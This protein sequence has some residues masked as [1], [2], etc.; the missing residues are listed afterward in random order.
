MVASPNAA[1]TQQRPD[2]Y[3]IFGVLAVSLLTFVMQFAMVSVSLE[4]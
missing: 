3:L 1:A 4:T 2:R